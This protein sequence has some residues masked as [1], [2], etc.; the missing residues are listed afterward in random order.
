MPHWLQALLP[1]W[2][3]EPES[4]EVIER[5]TRLGL[6]C[7]DPAEEIEAG[8]DE[9][10]RLRCGEFEIAL[11]ESEALDV[12][13]ST[14]SGLNEEE[15]EAIRGSNLT[16]RIETILGDKVLEDFHTSLRVLAAAA[17]EAI[18]MHDVPACIVR[19]GSWLHGAA[20]SFVP[21]HPTT[22]FTVHAVSYSS[23]A[24]TAWLH[25]HGLTRCGSI[26][27]ELLEVPREHTV[28]MCRSLLNVA[29]AL[30][31]EQ[32]VPMSST[33][34][35]IGQDLDLIWLPWD[36]ALEHVEPEVGGQEDRDD[37]HSWPSGVLFAPQLER[38]GFLKGRPRNPSVYL[39]ALQGNPLLYHSKMETRRMSMLAKELFPALRK[40]F[41]R[42]RDDDGW[43]FFVKLGYSVDADE[44]SSE[45]LWF[46]IHGIDKGQ[47][48]ATLINEPY[49]IERMK[50]GDRAVHAPDLISDWIVHSPHGK[51][52][53]DRIHKLLARL[54][55]EGA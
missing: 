22:L 14:R 49:G 15:I 52:V 45:H 9:I 20:A 50:L 36:E 54:E 27:L 1:G 35:R 39:E 12:L 18:A 3:P 44:D 32:G 11:V 38:L 55:D 47:I 17:P 24:S 25:T 40:L 2:S 48:D 26:D 5:V 30:F 10:W 37:D 8:E 16:I 29:A 53:P 23:D 19:P 33:P 46:E 51:Y 31:I 6:D 28:L 7:S 21:P 42:Y 34:F 41:T 43:N 13:R 4:I